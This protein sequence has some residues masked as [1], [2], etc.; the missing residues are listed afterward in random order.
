[1]HLV[2]L[3]ELAATRDTLLLRLLQTGERL[4]QALAEVEALPGDALERRATRAALL[5]ASPDERPVPIGDGA[6]DAVPRA[7]RK[8]YRRW[9]ARLSR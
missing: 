1:L 8:T 5:A 7:C 4:D 6:K 9:A 3:R 2:S